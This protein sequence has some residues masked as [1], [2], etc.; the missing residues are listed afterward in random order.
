MLKLEN[1]QGLV[2]IQTRTEE[3]METDGG[4]QVKGTSGQMSVNRE[5]RHTFQI[6]LFSF[7]VEDRTQSA[8]LVRQSL[9]LYL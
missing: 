3:A 1:L 8:P 6:F 4:I 2:I 7:M 9:G 5:E